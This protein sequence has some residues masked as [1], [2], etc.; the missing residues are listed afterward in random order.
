MIKTTTETK[1]S[2]TKTPDKYANKHPFIIWI[3]IS[4]NLLPDT[5]LS[6]DSNFLDVP[7]LL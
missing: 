7:L 2:K 1:R 6:F 5:A 4:H 3:Q